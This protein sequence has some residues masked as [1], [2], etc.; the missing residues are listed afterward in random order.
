MKTVPTK[1][2]LNKMA[3]TLG[4]SLR[5]PDGKRFN[6]SRKKTPAQKPKQGK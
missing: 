5:G 4:A 3:I 1:A 6:V 2:A